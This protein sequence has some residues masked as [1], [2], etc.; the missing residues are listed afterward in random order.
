ML[1]IR[2]RGGLNNLVGWVKGR[3]IELFQ[4]LGAFDIAGEYQIQ[5]LAT[6]ICNKFYYWT[7]AELDYAFLAF[8]NGEY[9]KL[10]HYNHDRE[11]S[12]INPQDVM[13]ALILYETDMLDARGK[14]E[15]TKKKIEA[16]KQKILDSKKPHGIEAW[17]IY[18]KSKGLDPDKH[19][20]ASVFIKDVNK[21]LNP[22]RD[23]NGII[24]NK[25]KYE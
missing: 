17:R 14:A 1:D 9:G 10:N 24:K 6:R 8:E 23:E 19:K 18:C 16:E 2:K 7:V 11:T 22:E 25:D 15:E 3:L 13:K 20:P 4:Y 12:V 21:V 5:M